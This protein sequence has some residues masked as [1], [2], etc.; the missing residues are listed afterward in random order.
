MRSAEDRVMGNFCKVCSR[1]CSVLRRL[2]NMKKQEDMRE[3]TVD[4]VCC[5]LGDQ[6]H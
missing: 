1:M 2:T 5:N 3:E 4:Q 6:G